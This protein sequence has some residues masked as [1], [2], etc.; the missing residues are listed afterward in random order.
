MTNA[1]LMKACIRTI[2]GDVTIEFE[3]IQGITSSEA[4]AVWGVHSPGRG[5][6]VPVGSEA[7][8]REIVRLLDEARGHGTAETHEAIVMACARGKDHAWEQIFRC[9]HCGFLTDECPQ[10]AE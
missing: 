1:E 10:N 2:G 6:F 9:R 8:A 3:A 4:E 7:R 5:G